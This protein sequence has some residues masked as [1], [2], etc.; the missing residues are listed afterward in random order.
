[1]GSLARGE[2][3]VLTGGQG[4]TIPCGSC[5]GADLTGLA[6]FPGIAGRSPS[7]MMRQLWDM[8]I[9]TRRGAQSAAMRQVIAN[10]SVAELTDIV[11]YLASLTPAAGV[12]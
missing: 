3:L 6:N 7:Y 9:G 1:M 10:L 5:H 2:N 4:K 11:A 8:K 12:R